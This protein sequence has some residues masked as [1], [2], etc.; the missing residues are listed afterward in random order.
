MLLRF[1][2]KGYCKGNVELISH[3]WHDAMSSIMP[4]GRN[5]CEAQGHSLL[6]EMQALVQVGILERHERPPGEPLED[7]EPHG[8]NGAYSDADFGNA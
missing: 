4:I 5:I 6:M 7:N 2:P 3:P 8:A 1:N